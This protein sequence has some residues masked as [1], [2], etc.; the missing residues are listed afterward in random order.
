LPVFDLQWSETEGRNPAKIFKV[1]RKPTSPYDK[2]WNPRLVV[3]RL[4]G[5]TDF[6]TKSLYGNIHFWSYQNSLA[7]EMLS[8]FPNTQN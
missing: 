1:S 2:L 5:L 6:P 7:T 3:S 4:Y 8:L